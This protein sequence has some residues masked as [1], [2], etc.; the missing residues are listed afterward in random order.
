MRKTP[1]YFLNGKENTEKWTFQP[2]PAAAQPSA[3]NFNISSVNDAINVIM[4]FLPT[5]FSTAAME[6]RHFFLHTNT[7]SVFLNMRGKA[8][9]DFER[10]MWMNAQMGFIMV[11]TSF[12]FVQGSF[13]EMSWRFFS[14][15]CRLLPGSDRG[16]DVRENEQ[17]FCEMGRNV[18]ALCVAWMA[19]EQTGIPS[20][21]VN[22]QIGMRY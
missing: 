20:M 11:R 16:F 13:S 5:R 7:H 10:L 8:K 12:F 4:K 1:R 3:D 21:T 18:G 15:S 14:L 22:L 6:L 2:P 17:F 9:S 19:R